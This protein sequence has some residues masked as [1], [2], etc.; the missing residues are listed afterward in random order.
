MKLILLKL[1][2]EAI[3]TELPED[4]LDMFLVRGHVCGIDE[5][6]VQVYYC[7]NIYKICKDSVDKALEHCQ[8]IGGTKGYH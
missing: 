8:N 6:V 1:D 7:T 2:K 3:C 4:F 5:D